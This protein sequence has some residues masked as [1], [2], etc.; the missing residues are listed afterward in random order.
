M[1]VCWRG[2]EVLNIKNNHI[3][4]AYIRKRISSFVFA[5]KGVV[6]TFL[7]QPNAKI[8]AVATVVVVAAG[9]WLEV[10][11]GE[12]CVLLLAIGLVWVAELANTAI[13]HL[14]DLISPGYQE[15]AGR[16]KDSAA[17]AVLIAA[18]ISIATGII[19]LFPHMLNC[20]SH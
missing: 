14:T 8:H 1:F 15:L 20:I 4:K 6:D 18:A 3:M 9:W 7:T 2:I 11:G 5:G 17:G 16:A 10:T 12:W 19:V 13:E